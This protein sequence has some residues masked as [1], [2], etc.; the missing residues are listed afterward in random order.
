MNKTVFITGA[1]SGIGRAAAIL[2]AEKKYN[3]IIC[4]RRKEKLEELENMLSMNTSVFSLCFDVSKNEEVINAVALLPENF[5]KVD[6]LVNNAGNAHGLAPIHDG[7]INDWDQMIDINVKG[8]LYVSKA[9]L[10][11][12]VASENGHIINIGSIAGKEVYQNGNV[13]NASKF[14][15]DAL[16]KAML[17]DLNAFGIRVSNINPGLVATEFSLVRFKGDAKRAENVYKGYKPLSAEDIAV[18]IYWVASRPLHVNIS[19]LTIL[20][21]AQASATIVKK[22]LA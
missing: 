18:T 14:A 11:K 15:V 7:N 21:T 13:Y 8:L 6:I 16:G 10:P 12:M 2:F 22:N 19:D 3:V 20:P 1:T 17:M 9:L 4:G 5:K